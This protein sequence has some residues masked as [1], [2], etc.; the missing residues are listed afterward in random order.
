MGIME[1][2][3]LLHIKP[4]PTDADIDA[5]LGAH[6]CRCGTY[7]RLRLAVKLAADYAKDGQR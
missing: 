6:V 3:A 2:A 1:T 4:A 5:S 7:D